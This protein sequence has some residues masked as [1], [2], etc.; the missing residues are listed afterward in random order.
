MFQFAPFLC[1][2]MR[3]YLF[4]V[5]SVLKVN[6]SKAS[7]SSGLLVIYDGDVCQGAIFRE[8]VPQVPLRGVQAQAK[9]SQA[10]VRIRICL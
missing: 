9:H 10:N 7:G 2:V 1:R 6:K 4:G 5:I 8:D 3:F